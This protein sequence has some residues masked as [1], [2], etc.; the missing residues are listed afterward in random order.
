M[1]MYTNSIITDHNL[2]IDLFDDNDITV[3]FDLNNLA[4][5]CA[6]NKFYVDLTEK[7]LQ[8]INSVDFIPDK[9]TQ[10]IKILKTFEKNFDKIHGF[11]NI[12]TS[13]TN[14]LNQF[15]N[16]DKN[17]DQFWNA[18]KLKFNV[19]VERNLKIVTYGYQFYP[20]LDKYILED[21]NN[22]QVTYDVRSLKTNKNKQGLDF[23]A[24]CKLRG[25]DL[26][27]QQEIREAEMFETIL[28]NIIKE[29][30]TKN[31]TYI[32]ICCNRGH[33]RSIACAEMLKYLYTN[34]QI[35]HLTL[36]I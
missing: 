18:S 20:V 14:L 22:I 15:K 12:S 26:K 33:H 7:L 4:Y 30:E 32:A 8:S 10:I 9:E 6:W 2:T 3:I 13:N 16:Y 19:D 21:Y 31:L 5:S 35:N 17:I 36:K 11:E 1:K 25:T 24:L 27:V 28:E 34:T 23:K 29:I